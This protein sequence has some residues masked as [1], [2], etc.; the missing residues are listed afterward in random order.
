MPMWVFQADPELFDVDSAIQDEVL[1]EQGMTWLVRQHSKKIKDG[2]EVLIYRTG[3]NRAIIAECKVF[4]EP[5][6][7]PPDENVMKYWT[8]KAIKNGISPRNR[9]WIEILSFNLTGITYSTIKDTPGLESV[10]IGSQ[11]TN[12]FIDPM[13][14]KILRKLWNLI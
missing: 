1:Q 11:G 4:D 13:E 3:K 8:E 10:S 12:I 6:V 5:R 2:D 7:Q 14:R 9:C